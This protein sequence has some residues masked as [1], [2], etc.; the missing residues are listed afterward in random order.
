VLSCLRFQAIDLSGQAR[1][2]SGGGV[3]VKD[4]FGVALPDQRDRF[5]QGISSLVNVLLLK[6]RSYP[7]DGRLDGALDVDVSNPSLLVLPC[8]LD[9]R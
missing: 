4:A 1:D 3:L 2:L 6:S 7:F 9:C 8:S 5:E